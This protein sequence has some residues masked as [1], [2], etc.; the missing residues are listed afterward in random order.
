MRSFLHQSIKLLKNDDII[1]IAR[2]GRV[3]L[4][5]GAVEQTED[6]RRKFW[7][8]LTGEKRSRAL[9]EGSEGDRLGIRGVGHRGLRGVGHRGLLGRGVGNCE[10]WCVLLR[11]F[12]EEHQK[13]RVGDVDEKRKHLI[14]ITSR[15]EP[16]HVHS[17]IERLG[18]LIP[19]S[20]SDG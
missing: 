11:G 3:Q 4:V 7:A 12:D 9:D 20:F 5:E 8:T 16:G 14:S 19:W 6:L 13:K 17:Q 2:V 15:K 10:K 18:L 1:R